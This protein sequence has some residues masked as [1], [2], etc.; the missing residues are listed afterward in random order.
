MPDN[1]MSDFAT[2]TEMMD[3]GCFGRLLGVSGFVFGRFSPGAV[4]RAAGY[5]YKP[6]GLKSE[7]FV[8]R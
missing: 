2:D 3:V 6:F 1:R 5:M 7:G 4:R 8:M